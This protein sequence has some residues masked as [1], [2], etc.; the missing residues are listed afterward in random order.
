M[1]TVTSTMSTEIQCGGIYRRTISEELVRY[2][3]SSIVFLETIAFKLK[4][5]DIGRNFRVAYKSNGETNCRG[6]ADQ[7]GRREHTPQC[8]VALR[9]GGITS[10]V[11][12][13]GSVQYLDAG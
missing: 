5:R 4:I 13:R 10:P 1:N 2:P 8:T 11:H 6:V 7:G 9:V 3:S 12:I